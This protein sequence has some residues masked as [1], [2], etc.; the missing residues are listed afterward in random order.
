MYM[1]YIAFY[2]DIIS[3]PQGSS[4]EIQKYESQFHRYMDLAELYYV[5]HR[6]YCF[7]EQPF[8]SHIPETLHNMSRFLVHRTMKTT[9]REISQ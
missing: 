4:L 3:D 9:P 8:T 2:C 1:Q 6:I 5:Y 7:V